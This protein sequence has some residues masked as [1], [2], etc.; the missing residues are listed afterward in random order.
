VIAWQYLTRAGGGQHS[1]VSRDIYAST[2]TAA[3]R[4]ETAVEI[5]CLNCTRYY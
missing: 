3:K 2:S 1:S 5:M 4:Q